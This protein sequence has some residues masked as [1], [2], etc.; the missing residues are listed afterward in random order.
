[1][2]DQDVDEC[3]TGLIEA[4]TEAA[5]AFHAA[6]GEVRSEEARQLLLDR[7]QR[8]GRAAASLRAATP[9]RA[10]AA[11]RPEAPPRIGP[12]DEAHLLEAC[13]RRESLVVVAFRDA[14]ERPLPPDVRPIVVA[15]FERL[16]GSLG[17]L[18]TVCERAARQRRFVIGEP[19]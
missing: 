3:V 7:A 4:V 18:R 14:L 17:S 2:S 10:P 1:M 11:R 13:E 12:A 15:E 9:G 6:A 8:Y 19:T 16:L 5:V